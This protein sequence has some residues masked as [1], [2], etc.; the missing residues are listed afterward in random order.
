MP[1]LIITSIYSTAQ[2]VKK[3]TGTILYQTN[4]SKGIPLTDFVNP[5]NWVSSKGGITSTAY[6]LENYLMLFRQYSINNRQ[7]AVMVNLGKDT[8]FNFFTVEMDNFHMW[9]TMVQVDVC[10]GLLKVYKNYN[11]DSA[12]YPPVLI[13]HPY[14]FI[15]GRD[16]TIAISYAN[17]VNKFTI[18]DHLTGVSD[19]TIDAGGTTSGLVRDGFAIATASGTPPI[20]KSFNVNTTYPKGIKILYI[21][22][23]ITE[24][25]F[26]FPDDFSQHGKSAISGRSSGIVSGVQNRVWSELAFL[27]P[28]YVSI[29]IGT[30]GS[31]TVA[32]LTT[33]CQ[34]IMRLGIIPILNNLPWKAP[35]SVKDDNVIISQ[36]RKNLKLEGA[37]FDIA[38]SVNNLNLQQD[39]TIFTDGV[40]P[41]EK[42]VHRMYLQLKSDVPV[43][44]R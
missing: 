34:S 10:N 22:D 21:G 31:N 41:N 7:G 25:L 27:K 4:F 43:S 1:T 37:R 18:T 5:G 24:G 20:V 23:S 15:P 14:K 44:F 2:P 8:R 11:A 39:T 38:T 40:H 6:G 29:L 12:A 19:S 42:G 16:Y 32:N 26:S 30:N 17:R 9:G 3:S 13:S 35:A 28:K 36:V 33:L